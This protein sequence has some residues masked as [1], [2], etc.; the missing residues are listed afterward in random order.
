MRYL[1]ANADWCLQFKA[2]KVDAL[3]LGGYTDS[4]FA[5][6]TETRRSTGGLVFTSHGA[7]IAWKSHTQ[8]TVAKSTVEAE[9]M[10]AA[11]A[12]SALQLHAELWGA[13]I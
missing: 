5:G 8:A 12:V 9:Y 10:A 3:E 1:S 7:A 2:D 6:D 4:D 11:A 13:E